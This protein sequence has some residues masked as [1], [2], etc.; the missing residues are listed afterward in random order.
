MVVGQL[1]S[2]CSVYVIANGGGRAPSSGTKKGIQG[3]MKREIMLNFYSWNGI[4]ERKSMQSKAWLP[5]V[6]PTSSVDHAFWGCRSS[7][8]Y[9]GGTAS[10]EPRGGAAA[11]A[12]SKCVNC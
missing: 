1:F 4:N 9:V 3:H 8:K 2:L 7:S 10:C 6:R 12:G 11:A 5:F